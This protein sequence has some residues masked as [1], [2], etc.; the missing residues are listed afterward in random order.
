MTQS[1]SEVLTL[2]A[3]RAAEGGSLPP[4]AEPQLITFSWEMLL[5]VALPSAA[6]A[7]LLCSTPQ[8]RR[9]V[10]KNSLVWAGPKTAYTCKTERSCETA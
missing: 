5:T 2:E 4:I 6:L 7:W 9:A 8:Q 3:G 1:I 10:W